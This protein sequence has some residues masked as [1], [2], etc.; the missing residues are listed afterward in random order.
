MQKNLV[1]VLVLTDGIGISKEDGGS[2]EKQETGS[3]KVF[4]NTNHICR[5]ETNKTISQPANHEGMR[6]RVH[7]N[8]VTNLRSAISFIANQ[9]VEFQLVCFTTDRTCEHV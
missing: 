2:D 8:S 4:R 1:Q 6:A 3:Q 5:Y 7:I 9:D